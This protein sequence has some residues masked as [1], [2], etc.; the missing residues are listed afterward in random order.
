MEFFP[1]HESRVYE[2]QT[3]ECHAL[4]CPVIIRTN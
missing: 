3:E 1:S 4:H 2:R